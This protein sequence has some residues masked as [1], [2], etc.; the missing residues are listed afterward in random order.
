M[1][2]RRHFSLII[3]LSLCSNKG[4]LFPKR[5]WILEKI[6]NAAVVRDFYSNRLRVLRVQIELNQSGEMSAA[7]NCLLVVTGSQISLPV[8]RDLCNEI[9]PLNPLHGTAIL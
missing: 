5:E 6:D 9:D 3:Y 4:R 1:S 8:H 7:D 2:V